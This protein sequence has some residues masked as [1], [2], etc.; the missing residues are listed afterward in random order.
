M[1][2]LKSLKA[3][4]FK[5]DRKGLSCRKEKE[6]RGRF[7]RSSLTS[8][9]ISATRHGAVLPRRCCRAPSPMSP[10]SSRRRS[11]VPAPCQRRRNPCLTRRPGR[12]RSTPL[13][14][15][16]CHRAPLP[17]SPRSLHR[18]P[19]PPCCGGGDKST[20]RHSSAPPL[21]HLPLLL[22][23]SFSSS[24]RNPSRGWSSSP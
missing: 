1:P 17:W 15:L 22:P 20:A 5:R 21:A 24:T 14:C 3:S 19:L 16:L 4:G 2:Q 6:S 7:A 11:R 18:G 9:S 10:C 12:I 13:H 8:C 23:L